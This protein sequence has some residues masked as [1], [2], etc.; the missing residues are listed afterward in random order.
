MNQPVMRVNKFLSECYDLRN[1][2]IITVLALARKYGINRESVVTWLTTD[3]DETE[4]LIDL[5]NMSNFDFD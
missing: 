3:S 4:V 2:Y 5:A 1:S